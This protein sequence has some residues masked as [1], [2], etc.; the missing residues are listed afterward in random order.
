MRRLRS[1]T[2]TL[3]GIGLVALAMVMP[4]GAWA[5]AGQSGHV[6]Q[7]AGEPVLGPSRTPLAPDQLAIDADCYLQCSSPAV[8]RSLRPVLQA[9]VRDAHDGL[10]DAEFQVRLGRML[11][12]SG[13]VGGVASGGTAQ[14]Q[15]EADLPQEQPLTF[16]VRAANQHGTGPWSGNF[17]F[18][19]DTNPPRVPT[20][21]SELY[22]PKD[23][24]TFNGGIG[25]PGDF[26]F[27]SGSSDVIEYGYRWLGGE[28]TRI[29][30]P[31]G[32]AV[33]V[34]LAPLGD[35]EQV[36]E[37]RS[38]DLAGNISNWQSYAFL[39]N[40]QPVE[41]TH[42]KFDEGTGGVAAPEPG[43]GDFPGVL[44][45]NAGWAPSGI[46]PDN[47]AASGTAVSLDGSTAFVEMPSVLVTDHA[48]GFTVTTWVNP[49][50]LTGIHAVVAQSGQ[51]VPMFMIYYDHG[52]LAWCLRVTGSDDPAGDQAEACSPAVPQVDTWTN[53]AAVYDKPAGTIQLWVNGGPNSGEFPPGTV[54]EVAAPTGQWAATG[55]FTVGGLPSNDHFLSGR[56][57]EL[58]AYQ[59]VLVESEMQFL[60]L[61]CRYGDCP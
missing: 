4:A 44:R 58:R 51:N 29:Q 26:T 57:D 20:V 35:L 10:L 22:L 24:G 3:A 25:Q 16:R 32:A 38:L 23:T 50:Q 13:T 5:A 41:F 1:G 40:P 45:G 6:V 46:N 43:G 37:V 19:P 33:T 21:A 27:S 8:V 34:E 31:K 2:V 30:V 36:L 61:Q 49:D 39:V 11:L 48:A 52:E 9:R 15:P 56:V 12:M 59:R 47:P 60:F 53:L 42:W 54:T 17:Y 28:E 55:P 14:W 18:M 7:A